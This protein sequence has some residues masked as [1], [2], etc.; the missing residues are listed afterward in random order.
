M[1][2]KFLYYLGAGAS[3][4]S[5]PMVHDLRD[6]N[7]NHIKSGILTTMNSFAADLKQLLATTNDS[8]K[9]KF[10][11]DLA[12]DLV[13]LCKEAKEFHTIDTYAKYLYLNE[14]DKLNILKKT[15]NAFLVLY[16]SW[17][18]TIDKRY[19]SWITSVM[20]INIF[21]DNV[22][23][24]SWNYDY[25]LQL[26]ASRFKHEKNYRIG[27]ATSKTPPLIRYFPSIGW[28]GPPKTDDLLS[29]LHLNGLSGWFYNSET[30]LYDSMYLHQE[31]L[32]KDTSLHHLVEYND[33]HNISF[34]W[35][36]GSKQDYLLNTAHK[37]ID[38]TTIIIIIGYSFPFFNRNIDNA[39]FSKIKESNT[40]KKIY[41]Q[42]PNLN[43]EFLRAQ[44]DLKEDIEIEHVSKVDSFYIP[45]EL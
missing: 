27:T 22:K 37:M 1:K 8:K 35:E 15:L 13:W 28:T 43:G 39:I 44:F 10:L 9:R 21:P 31:T 5:L 41:F 40:L 3:A 23:I 11:S 18:T 25:Q 19:L 16:Q 24:I 45:F 30:N 26:A 32:T 42:D 2:E 6:K 20:D 34:A 14:I 36:S 12:N 29:L 38:G 4:Q 33:S 7:G 17:N